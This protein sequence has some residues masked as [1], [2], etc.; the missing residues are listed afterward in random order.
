M[1]LLKKFFFRLIRKP[2]HETSRSKITIED[3]LLIIDI[4]TQLPQLASNILSNPIDPQFIGRCLPSPEGVPEVVQ[5]ASETMRVTCIALLKYNGEESDPYILGIFSDVSN[6]GYFQRT[7][8]REMLSFV[9]RTIVR[10]T[11]PGQRQSVQH[12]GQAFI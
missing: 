6:F 10:R 5:R 11:A 9:S 2:P 12:E 3:E 1:V 4:T 8:V 7:T